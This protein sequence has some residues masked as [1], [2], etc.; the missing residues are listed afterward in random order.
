MSRIWRLLPHALCG[1]VLVLGTVAPGAHAADE[2][3]AADT[4]CARPHGPPPGGKPPN[5]P[6]PGFRKGEK[7]PAPPT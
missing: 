5:G 6:P 3:P 7:P 1:A 2:S 4:K